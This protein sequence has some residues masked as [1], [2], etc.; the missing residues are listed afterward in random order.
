M[1][2]QF[3]KAII[4]VLIEEGGY[5][6]DPNDFG[7]ETNFGISK[8]QYP[9]LDIRNLKQSDA[10][11]IYRKDFWDKFRI[12]ELSNQSIA[13]VILDIF[14]N[15]SSE[16]AGIIIQ[17][18]LNSLNENIKVDG[19]MGTKTIFQINNITNSDSLLD[20]IKIERI[21]FYLTRV[22]KDRTQMK[23][24]AGWIGRTLRVL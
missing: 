18:S 21:I 22:M 10:I 6:R 2:A 19:I 4:Q 12:G 13:N 14:V 17:N 23:Y 8:R 3:E 7:G 16:K 9:T 20:K 1:L 5:T 24:L 11:E 15:I